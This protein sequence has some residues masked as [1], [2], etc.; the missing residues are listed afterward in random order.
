LVFWLDAFD[1][2]EQVEPQ[3][4]DLRGRMQRRLLCDFPA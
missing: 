1:H 3:L 2:G 4:I